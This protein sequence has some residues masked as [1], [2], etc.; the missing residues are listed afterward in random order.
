ME[1]L[2]KKSKIDKTIFGR[3]PVE[4]IGRNVM[5]YDYDGS[6]LYSYSG[7]EFLKMTSLPVLPDRTSENL[8]C[9]GWNWTLSAIKNH[10]SNVGGIVNVG[11]VYHTTDSKTHITCKPTE[12][13]RTAYITLTPTVANAV[14]VDW[15]DGASDIWT[16]ASQALKTHLYSSVTDTSVYEITISCSSGT[17]SFDTYITGSEYNNGLCCYTSIKM[18]VN[19]TSAGSHCFYNCR[20]LKSIV[21]SGG[22][23]SVGA[24][25]FEE[26]GLNSIT[27][28]DTVTAFPNYCFA[29]KCLTTV[30]VPHNSVSFG[31]Y[32]FYSCHAL[33]SI[34]MPH[35][36]TGIGDRCFVEC[37]S[38]ASVFIPGSVTSIP[39]MCFYYC[40]GFTSVVI[41]DSVVSIGYGAFDYCYELETVTMSQGLTS[42][43]SN[44]FYGCVSLKK[45]YCRPET[46]PVLAQGSIESTN[47]LVIYVPRG[48]LDA[49]QTAS[50]WSAYASKMKEYDY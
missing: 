14:T 22:V 23:T 38:L 6:L 25:C 15:G 44:S 46:P 28:P 33:K 34:T 8:T 21:I 4:K 11:A 18:A 1:L 27:F 10:I 24:S 36:L 42:I 9:D 43:G 26:C 32:T 40:Y 5:F 48:T 41:P 7:D 19:V 3:V 31:Q 49:Y 20:S 12:S 30:I 37:Y 13:Y 45:I 39:N 35:G 47:N 17:Y 29:T 50:N 16:S 2:L